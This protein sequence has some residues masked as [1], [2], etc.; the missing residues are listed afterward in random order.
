MT[1]T[2]TRRVTSS[3]VADTTK[4][5]ASSGGSASATYGH[6]AWGNSWGNSW[7]RSWTSVN[8][9]GA[10]TPSPAVN[11]TARIGEAP[12]SSLTKRVTL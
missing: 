3:P 7:G 11:V 2:I 10:A 4:R 9:A 6:S 12:E 1:T 8:G 5:V